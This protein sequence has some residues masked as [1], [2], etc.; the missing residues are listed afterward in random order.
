MWYYVFAGVEDTRGF[1]TVVLCPGS[2]SG[3]G[4]GPGPDP[5]PGPDPG[6]GAGPGVGPG[7]GPAFW[8]LSLFW[9]WFGSCSRGPDE[10]EPKRGRG[11]DDWAIGIIIMVKLHSVTVCNGND[12]DGSI[13]C[14][15]SG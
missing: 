15:R 9:S 1:R 6:R 12:Q 10:A 2:G 8:S 11:G 3:S 14:G 5:D 13:R 4:P 7:A